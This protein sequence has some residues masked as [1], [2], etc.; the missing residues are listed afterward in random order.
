[1]FVFSLKYQLPC[2]VKTNKILDKLE[3]S[4]EELFMHFLLVYRVACLLYLSQ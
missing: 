2:G 3:N 1:M 4:S